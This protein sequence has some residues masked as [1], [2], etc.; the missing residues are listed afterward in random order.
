MEDTTLP[1]YMDDRFQFVVIQ[2]V[3]YRIPIFA[4]TLLCDETFRPPV[5]QRSPQPLE[6]TKGKESRPNQAGN[7][8]DGPH[9]SHDIN[10]LVI[11][12]FAEKLPWS[13]LE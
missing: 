11:F 1:A 13:P 2:A 10:I 9:T 6:G 12:K 7:N 4:F 3:E 8:V 5:G